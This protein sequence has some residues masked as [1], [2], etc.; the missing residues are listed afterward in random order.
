MYAPSYYTSDYKDYQLFDHKAV[1]DSLQRGESPIKVFRDALKKGNETLKVRFEKKTDNSVETVQQRA[2]LIDQILNHVWEIL[3]FPDTTTLIAGGGYGRYELHPASDID[4][5]IL[6]KNPTD[7]SLTER[8]SNFIRFLWDIGLDVGPSVRTLEECVQAAKQDITVM[9]NLIEM[10]YLVGS[11]NLFKEIQVLTSPEHIWNSK[12]FFEAKIA[13]QE[14]RHLKYHDS[15]Y[16]LEPNVKEG[17]GGLRDI[18]T[19]GW[20]AKRHFG[21]Y[22]LYG[23]VQHGFL[24]SAEYEKLRNAQNFYWKI[25]CLLHSI[26]GRKEDRL[27]FDYQ[28]ILAQKFG[29]SDNSANLAVEEFMKQ[30]YRA[31]MEVHSLNDML[32]QLFREVILYGDIPTSTKPLNKRFQIRND[33][34]EVVHDKI[35]AHY[36]FALL[37][38]FLLMQQNPEIKGIRASTIR[39]IRQYRYLIDDAFREDLRSR[40]LFFEIFCQPL[41]LTHALRRMNRYG[42][43][44]AYIPVFGKIAGQMQYDLFHAYTVDQHSIFVVSNLRRFAMPEHYQD[45][46]FCSQIIQTLPKPE[47]L[48]IA[49]LFHDV[50]KGRG[51]DHSEL[52]AVDALHFCKSHGFSD[53]DARFVAWLVRNHLLMSTT[54]QRK[55][56][57]DPNVIHNF[58]QKVGDSV[59]LDYLYLLTV[60][61]IRATNPNLWNSWKES[62]LYDLYQS[63]KHSLEHGLG[64]GLG[65][66]LDKRYRIESVRNDAERLLDGK[67]DERIANLWQ[68]LGDDYFLYSTPENIV[69]ETQTIL[70]HDDPQK[71]LVFQRRYKG[72]GTEIIVYAPNRPLLFA[73]ITHFFERKRL[74]VVNAYVIP[75]QNEHTLCTYTVL[76]EDGKEID[77]NFRTPSI[78]KELQQTLSQDNKKITRNENNARISRQFKN[79][80]IET[81]VLFTQSHSYDH[82]IVE[83][84]TLDRPGVLSSI[85]QTFVS[86]EVRVKRAKIGSFGSRVEDIFFITDYKNHALYS[87]AQLDCLRD[88][89]M[90]A[91][92]ANHVQDSDD[93][94]TTVEKLS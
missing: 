15:A 41:G 66:N 11:V 6:L 23:L 56:T 13:E 26:A 47:L 84:T 10:R 81:Q 1:S 69:Y 67:K 52:G 71:P 85:A 12:D 17:P 49:G 51:G 32:L 64:H 44:S 38:I 14:K 55:D 82:T 24:T 19:I 80:P 43:L 22:T 68:E 86:C 87:S 94:K 35:F 39:L 92:D 72:R 16:N 88:K 73:E 42:I 29:Y 8:I 9:T 34:I 63:T 90:T 54:A 4:L 59:Y 50:A 60:A 65:S 83:I 7:E 40:S 33:Y 20:V 48:Y 70:N 28:R 57:S 25:R 36:P 91:L 58:A 45:F 46:P 62:L 61:D 18:H 31:I 74:D 93:S 76:E 21:A 3:D 37:E 75:T 89:L 30:Y 53:H 5:M 79:F 2:W 77:E 27:L 78:L